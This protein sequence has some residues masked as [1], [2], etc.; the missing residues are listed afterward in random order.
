MTR[1][2][3]TRRTVLLLAPA[4]AALPLAGCQATRDNM[5]ESDLRTTVLLYLNSLRWGNYGTAATLLRRQDGSL[6][7]RD[8]SR[9]DGLRLTHYDFE[10]V[11][12][13]PGQTEAL[14]IATMQ[15]YWEDQGN[16]RKVAQQGNW[17]WDPQAERWY[18]ADGLPGFER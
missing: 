15:Y 11:G 2:R 3:L 5:R 6:P 12:G 9:L 8:I 14:M 10:I 4:L 17:W 1:Q 18:L 7:P 13:E 16:I